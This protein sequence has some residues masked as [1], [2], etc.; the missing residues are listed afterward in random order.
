[1]SDKTFSIIR[2]NGNRMDNVNEETV[3]QLVKN[4]TLNIKDSISDDGVTWYKLSDV[5]EVNGKKVTDILNPTPWQH[6]ELSPGQVKNFF[7]V[8][9]CVFFLLVLLAGLVGG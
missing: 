2:V 1:M 6:R 8:V 5:V 7:A 9:L 3:I 4:D